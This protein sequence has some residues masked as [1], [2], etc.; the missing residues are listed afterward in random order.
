MTVP[1]DAGD[2]MRARN[3]GSDNAS[4][5]ATARRSRQGQRHDAHRGRRSWLSYV[6]SLGPGVMAGF[7]DNDPAGVAT[8]AIAGAVAGYSQL[9]L[10]VLATFMVQ[11]VQVTS[12]RLGDVTHSG[13]LRLARVRYG[14]SVAAVIGLFG[15]VANEATLIADTAALGAS[16][17]LL[18]G[19][20]WQ[21]FVIPSSVGLTLLTVF[22]NFRWLRNVFMAIGALLLTYV[23]TAFLV[24]PDWG[25]V[26]RATF[27]PTLPRGLDEIAAAVALLGTT[28]SPYLVFWQAE[29]EREAQRTSR[30]FRYT[31]VDVTVGYVA[32]NLVSFFIIVTTAATLY[33]NQQM[34][35]TAEDAAKALRPL[36]GDLSSD[37]FA[38][39]LLAAGILAIP[40]FAIC[41]GYIA[42]ELFGWQSGLSR[43]PR[44]VPGFYMVLCAA[45]L[46]GSLAVFLGVDP[47]VALFG[48][49]ILDGCLMPALIVVLAFLA[50][51]RRV[52]GRHRNTRYYNIWLGVAFVVMMGGVVALVVNL[53]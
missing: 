25:A 7:A 51:D 49:Q 10:L 50:N 16:F 31:V 36:A 37:I 11:A 40:V 9:W 48:S 53:R 39:G 43:S 22:C 15:I 8:Y 47:M 27:V 44:D 2:E 18:T 13:I 5:R 38:V 21:W 20:P 26:L 12:A 34:I 24:Q 42:S 41:N 23:V 35:R 17:E 14:W 4:N 52:M 1:F 33:V 28:I 19:I 3:E 29:G 32:S 6:R 45:F 30:E 46:L